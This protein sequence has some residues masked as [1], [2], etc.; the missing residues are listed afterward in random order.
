[1]TRVGVSLFGHGPTAYP[2]AGTWCLKLYPSTDM[3][4]SN[5]RTESVNSRD[6]VAYS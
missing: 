1:M 3:T 4:R 6:V 2:W 5:A